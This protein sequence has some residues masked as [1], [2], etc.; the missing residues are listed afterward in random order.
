MHVRRSVLLAM[1]GA[2]VVAPAA[3][4][5]TSVGHSGWSWA[6][7]TPQ[8]QTLNDVR[9]LGEYGY[10]VGDFG[11][12]LRTADGGLTW[13]GLPS[14]TTNDLRRVEGPDARTVAFSGVCTLGRS[15]DAGATVSLAHITG[16]SVGCT[17]DVVAAP[18]SDARTGFVLFADGTLL[19]TSDGGTTFSRR[20]A[21]P[22]SL[23]AGGSSGAPADMA[24]SGG[25]ILVAEGGAVVRSIDG[26]STWTTVIDQVAPAP[27]PH[28]TSVTMVTPQVGY[29]SISSPAYVFRTVDGG[30]TWV[31]HP[32]PDGS[33]GRIRCADVNVCLIAGRGNSLLRTVDGA[34]TFTSV[35]PSEVA[36]NSAAFASAT[37]AVAVGQSGFTVV[38]D[39]AGVTW[40]PV[41]QRVTDS[42]TGVRGGPGVTVA[43]GLRG[44]VQSSADGGTT[45]TRGAIPSSS[46]VK[47][48]AF[49]TPQVGVALA[50]DGGVW[51]TDNSGL[52]W[53][54]LDPGP[55]GTTL[56]TVVALSA[57]R[58][59]LVGPRDVRVSTD[60][61][62]FTRV[63][64]PLVAKATDLSWAFPVR[65]GLV[66][67]GPRRILFSA[68]GRTKWTAVPRPTRGGRATV[69][70]ALDCTAAGAC[71]ATNG[72]RLYA[73]PDLG[74]HWT[75]LTAT[76]P[77]DASRF[78][79]SATPVVRDGKHGHL[80]IYGFSNGVSA[81]LVQTALY[82]AD[83]GRTWTPQVVG[84]QTVV[85]GA[86][87]SSGEVLVGAGGEVF[88][89]TTHGVA[90]T[91]T[92][93]GLK[94]SKS[95]IT[96]PTTVTIT[97]RL[98]PALG[99]ETVHVTAAGFPMKTATV[100]AAGTFSLQ[101]RVRRTTTFVAHWWGDG[102]RQ[103][104]GSPVVTVTK[105]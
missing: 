80:L 75:D 87:T 64:D 29:A 78:G 23:A 54:L 63:A 16:G 95:T 92:V 28:F 90:G 19:A 65:G 6:A 86:I 18:F 67:A 93:L 71:W 72:G 13:E 76:L 33:G 89:S 20:T 31:S 37:R 11:T 105:K 22:G 99:G 39:D 4:A 81:A 43:W 47:A 51:R 104:D 9:F 14:G 38:S 53:Q 74:K 59:A 96:R 1:A 27:F 82:T 50:S 55:A 3:S 17:S 85:G 32:I 10:A 36:L 52:S 58:L 57:T 77:G 8:G 26:G 40:R 60:G 56:R 34:A 101:Y 94:P 84:T 73:T 97:G 7:P 45:W 69:I 62:T 21:V 102:A 25:T 103:G 61:T 42:L 15:L 88:T 66:V 49:A 83:G 41:G 46:P 48:A 24:L 12:L 98:R 91:A 44:E 79:A 70:G 100:S 68:N 35:T 5:A 2:A 30:A